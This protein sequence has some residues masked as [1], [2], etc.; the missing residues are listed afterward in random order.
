MTYSLLG[1]VVSM[2]TCFFVNVYGMQQVI[3]IEESKN[4]KTGYPK[5][6]GLIELKKSGVLT[7]KGVFIMPYSDEAKIIENIIPF[8]SKCSTELISLRPDGIN[9]I[10]MTPP[11]INFNKKDIALIVQ[12]LTEWGTQGYGVTLIET[13][14]RFDYDFCC[15]V[16]LLD[17]NGS[18]EIEF[19]GPGY[20]GGDLNKSILTAQMLVQGKTGYP[21]TDYCDLV[22]AEP[23][24]EALNSLYLKISIAS[25]TPTE[26]EVNTRLKYAMSKLLPDMGINVEKTLDATKAWLIRN[27]CARFLEKRNPRT[28]I[29]LTDLQQI[30]YS[31]SLYARHLALCSQKLTA[32]AL[33]AHKYNHNIIFIGTY[34]SQK[35]GTGL[36]KI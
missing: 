11:G 13:H 24:L 32:R 27:Q 33:T 12:K 7:P 19:V 17:E 6:D 20:D 2:A 8:I 22:T 1:R 9:G 14:N 25:R 16:L 3:N 18:Y 21:I 30:V 4:A 28:I 5:W 34:D 23:N 36:A 10:G 29:S 26:E 31:A 15:N 35:W